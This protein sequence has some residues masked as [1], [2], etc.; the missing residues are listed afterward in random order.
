MKLLDGRPWDDDEDPTARSAG[1]ERPFTAT[2]VSLA[3]HGLLAA[4]AAYAMAKHLSRDAPPPE[5]PPVATFT[6]PSVDEP[7]IVELPPATESDLVAPNAP[8]AAKPETPPAPTVALAGGA[9]V[10]H[11]DEANAGKGGDAEAKAKARNLAARADED[12]VASAL[13]DDVLRDQEN[14]LKTSHDRE[15]FIDRREALEPMELTFVASGKG[16]RYD[17]K[18]V[19]SSDAALGTPTSKS[20]SV[21]GSTIGGAPKEGE[22]SVVAFTVAS[23]DVG[24][25]VA[26]S[27]VAS[28]KPGAAYGV[29]SVGTMQIVGANV[30]K[31]RP[32][33]DKGKPSV[34]ANDKGSSKDTVDSDLAVATALKSLV[35]TS[36]SG[37]KEIGEGNGGGG[38]GGDPGSGGKYGPGTSSIAMGDGDGS[39]DGPREKRRLSYFHDLWKRLGPVVEKTFPRED[40]LELRSGTVIV[41]IVIGKLGNVVD[42]VVIRPS[43]FKSF[44]V[45]VVTAIR[46]AGTLE[47]VP[48]V[49]G[50]GAITVRVP[51]QGGFRLY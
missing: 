21:I 33:V 40:E 15:S 20:P 1:R 27:S 9:S 30:T 4:F 32:D 43:G 51:V 7:I 17:R 34:S 10:A 23:K 2:I 14:R 16:F 8:N 26:G 5:P 11:P 45:N 22:G 48:D 25:S 37:S 31:A 42:V 28:P 50:D 41:D 47:P 18:P 12:T 24:G 44:D 13:R 29:A 36:T 39:I 6:P 49:L 19:A 3:A 38:G 46:S 35:D